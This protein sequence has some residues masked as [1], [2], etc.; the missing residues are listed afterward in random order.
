MCSLMEGLWA[1]Q[2]SLYY[3]GRTQCICGHEFITQ[4]RRGGQ[5]LASQIAS[6]SL[7]CIPAHIEVIDGLVY[8]GRQDILLQLPPSGYDVVDQYLLQYTQYDDPELQ[9]PDQQYIS[10]DQY[11][12]HPSVDAPEPFT[13][14]DDIEAG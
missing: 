11:Q 8:E 6:H 12:F 9:T 3:L 7:H 10:Q 1:E 4:R 13:E 2:L 14:H 5:R